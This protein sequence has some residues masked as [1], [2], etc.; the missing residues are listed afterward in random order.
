MEVYM[1]RFAF[2]RGYPFSL[3]MHIFIFVKH[4]NLF[5][6]TILFLPMTE[7]AGPL[8]ALPQIRCVV[9]L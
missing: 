8:Y 2:F 4:N 9:S 7:G 5:K 3:S 6:M 1:K